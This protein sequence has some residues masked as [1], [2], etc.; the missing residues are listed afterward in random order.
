MDLTTPVS[1]LTRVGKT[2]SK[3]LESLGIKNIKDLLHY[4]PFRYEDYR[5]IVDISQLRDGE[6]VTICGQVELIANKRSFKTKRVITEALVS[7]KTGSVR[8]VWFNQ[9]FILKSIKSGDRVYLS[10]K[11]KVDMLGAQLVSPVY[12]KY[13][14]DTT[15]TARLVPIYP[16]IYGLTQKQIRFLISQIIPLADTI[17]DWL[18]KD[19][20][21]AMDLVPLANALRG[22]HFPVDEH[23][24]Q[25]STDR[26][27]FNELFLVQIKSELS[28]QEKAA[29]KAPVIMF[30]EE[31]IKKFVASLPF[32]LTKTQKIS[33]WEIL[34]DISKVSPMN[35]LI[36]GD[37]GSGKTVVA[38]MSMYNVF[39]NGYQSVMMAPTEILAYQHYQSLIRL[40]SNIPIRIGLLTRSQ[41]QKVHITQSGNGEDAAATKKKIIS[42]IKSGDVD[43]MVGTHA[44]LSESVN[45]KNL[46]LVIVDEQHRF[47]V[48]QRKEIKNKAIRSKGKGKSAHFLSMTATPIPRSLALMVYGDLDV[49]IISEL[50]P[51]RKKIITK[52]V[53]PLS[54]DK[55]YGFIRDQV[56]QGRQV[57]VVCPLI[58]SDSMAQF[59]NNNLEKKSVLSEYEKLSKQ[60]FPD[61]RVQY[62]HGKLKAKEK[63]EIMVR[64]KAGEF[65]ILATTSVIEVGV[66]VPNASVMM[67]EGAESFG[68][69][70][71]H[72]FRGRVGR[73][74]YQSYCLLFTSSGSEKSLQ[75][76]KFF[77]GENNGF[78]L[79]EKD[80]EIRGPGEV[81]G[82]E[83]SGEMNLRLAKLTDRELI[84]KAR[85]AAKVIV[86]DLQKFSSVLQQVRDWEVKTHLE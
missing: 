51:G 50:P 8:V 18:P 24:L 49:S 80:L 44:L 23:D 33:A 45:F 76:L 77:E 75:R 12:E 57:F 65:D 43:I 48:E 15:H 46:G 13:K 60:V 1:E 38:A 19:I 31:E 82:T 86:S 79:A 67:I 53:E 42:D 20:I 71:L 25:L 26:L 22:I 27:K 6:L 85:D 40:F 74:I 41:S 78:K 9:P 64:F 55:A 83:Q 30:Q 39:L 52:L 10:G 63:E 34:Q 66:D 58:E 3:I 56:K 36:S 11:V 32:I 62:L 59:P 81:Y 73:S 47:G 5:A 61:L 7:D 28:R 17:A 16:L 54:R 68:L 72:Q 37:V 84:K 4:F 35:R 2:A 14:K 69:A 29:L 21:E 70:Q